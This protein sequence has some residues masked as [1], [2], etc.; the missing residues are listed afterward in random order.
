MAVD[1]SY[2][3]GHGGAPAGTLVDFFPFGNLVPASPRFPRLNCFLV[4]HLPN[5]M[6]RS[7]SLKFA[8]D[9]KWAIEQIHEAP[10][11]AVEKAI[12]SSLFVNF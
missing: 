2:A 1:A 4:K 7:Q 3:L 9:W 10:F 6:A 5:W 12:V 8:R 11:A